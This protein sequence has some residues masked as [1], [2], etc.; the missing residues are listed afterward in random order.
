MPAYDQ[1]L[2]SFISLLFAVQIPDSDIHEC[3]QIDEHRLLETC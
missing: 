3:F 1:G 2:G